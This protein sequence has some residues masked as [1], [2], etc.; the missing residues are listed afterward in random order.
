MAVVTREFLLFEAGGRSFGLHIDD[1][2]RVVHAVRPV[3]LPH[4]PAAI[5]GIFN[6]HGAAVPVLDLSV[7]FGEPPKEVRLDDLFVVLRTSGRKVAL[8]VERA[9]GVWEI[10]A[11]SVQ[12]AD[13]AL[14]SAGH[15]HGVTMID[16]HIVFLPDIQSFL[17][18]VE[19]VQTYNEATAA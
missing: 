15:F 7:W 13:S 18:A 14:V 12:P 10:P 17:A 19:Q 9:L 1:V 3:P 6:L 16:S 5:E 8:H 2:E 4:S 11:A